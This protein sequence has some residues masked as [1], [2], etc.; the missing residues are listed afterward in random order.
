MQKTFILLGAIFLAC[1]AQA[2]TTDGNS[3]IGADSTHRYGMHRDGRH[4]EGGDRDGRDGFRSFRHDGGVAQRLHYSP[5]QRGQIRDINTDYHKKAADLFKNDNQTLG[6]YKAGLIALQKDKKSK[7]QALLTPVQ[8][9]RLAKGKQRMAEN[10]QVMAA[11]RMERLKIRLSLTD[12]QVT[13][14]K[15]KEDALHTQLKAIHENDDLLPQQKMEQYK[16][17]MGKRKEIVK[18]VLTP[19]QLTKFSE[20]ESAHEGREHR[21]MPGMR[22]EGK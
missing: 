15:T 14:L 10:M 1:S 6:Q 20:M 4:R 13:T 12:Q 16:E 9:E 18:S 2:Q 21:Y 7:L 19:D 22:E 8:K 5:E 3:N 11:A 17:L